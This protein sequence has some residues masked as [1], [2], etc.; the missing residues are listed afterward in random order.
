MEAKDSAES[1]HFAMAISRRE[2]GF[3]DTGVR[4]PFALSE[5]AIL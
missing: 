2:G 4:L 5:R 1:N 3:R